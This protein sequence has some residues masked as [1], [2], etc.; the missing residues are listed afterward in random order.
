MPCCHFVEDAAQA[1]N[2]C[3]RVEFLASRLLWRHVGGRS[4][5][6]TRAGQRAII[7]A[8]RRCAPCGTADFLGQRVCLGAECEL[9]Q[10]E[11]EDFRFATCRNEDVRRLDI[12]VDNPLGMGYAQGVGN[13]VRAT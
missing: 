11:V 6:Y 9:Y 5:R 4:K 2:V 7:G 12:P 13:L 3:A 1:E 10:A 8:A